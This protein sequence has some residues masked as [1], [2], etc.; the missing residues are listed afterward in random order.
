MPLS[1]EQIRGRLV[2]EDS[3][4]QQGLRLE[5]QY[6]LGID[7]PVRE[8]SPAQQGLRQAPF[9]AV[10]SRAQGSERIVQHNKD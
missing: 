2:R 4:A 10:N 8:D 6:S 3:P 7:I 5:N 1:T 9:K